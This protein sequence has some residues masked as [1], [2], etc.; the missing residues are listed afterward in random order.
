MSSTV[1]TAE[2]VPPQDTENQTIA[3][4]AL[5]PTLPEKPVVTIQ[6]R[7]A[8]TLMDFRELW[9]YRELLYFLTWRDVKVRYKQTILGVAWV[10]LQPVLSTIIFTIFLGRLARVPS[11]GVPYALLVFAGLLPWTFFATALTTASVSLVNH[12]HLITKT[13]FPRMMIPV[14]TICARLLDFSISFVVLM[15]L[16]IIYHVPFSARL[17]GIL[18]LLILTALLTTAVGVWASAI[19]VKYRDVGVA[20]PVLT[21]LWMFASP[22]V[23]PSTLIYSSHLSP[24][25]KFVYS[26]NPLVGIVDNFRALL[27]GLPFNWSGLWVSVSVTLV[28]LVIAAF[29]F[30]RMERIFADVV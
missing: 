17:L 29:E 21:Q 22:V 2:T 24:I 15:G 5:L 6:A 25:W 16:M 23:Y 27:F 11:D 26:L 12:A 19:N 1:T 20:I 13:Y 10:V 7:S 4:E 9:H 28:L 14:A 30:R 18:P 8:W 3:S